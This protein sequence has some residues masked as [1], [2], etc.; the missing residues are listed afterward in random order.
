M[1]KLWSPGGPVAL[2]LLLILSAGVWWAVQWRSQPAS[3]PAAATLATATF[4]APTLTDIADIA[5]LQE[6][7]NQDASHP[8]L[9]IL[10]SPT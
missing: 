2:A 1:K 6:Q 10:V 7:F 4:A 9:L 5:T 3:T 8:R